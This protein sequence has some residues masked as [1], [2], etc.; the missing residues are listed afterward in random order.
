[1]DLFG[2]A[3]FVK[4]TVRDE[5]ETSWKPVTV[6]VRRGNV[7]V[8]TEDIFRQISL[9]YRTLRGLRK[10]RSYITRRQWWEVKVIE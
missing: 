3:D 1:M 9:I 4:F 8:N 7:E 10:T 2:V 6:G 5:I